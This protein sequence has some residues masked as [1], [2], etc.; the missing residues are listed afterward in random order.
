MTAAR[1]NAALVVV[2][3]MAG[4]CGDDSVEVGPTG[5]VVDQEDESPSGDSDLDP[6]DPPAPTIDEQASST[7][8][9]TA[10]QNDGQT[11]TTS[12]QPGL[13]PDDPP[14]STTT[15]AAPTTTLEPPAGYEAFCQLGLDMIPLT[16]E[17]EDIAASD[18]DVST[19]ARIYADLADLMVARGPDLPP[20]PVADDTAL[21]AD[22][23]AQ[24]VEVLQDYQGLFVDA[25][26][27]AEDD[28]RLSILFEDENEFSRAGDRWDAALEEMCGLV[29]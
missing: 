29:L 4:A 28:E 2:V 8:T 12:T 11:A 22:G 23:L 15:I 5:S 24:I 27:E 25:I 20:G 10:G 19:V 7:T 26:L 9:T 14:D 16:R 3:L 13:D 1:T 18:T 21:L 17:V 6:D